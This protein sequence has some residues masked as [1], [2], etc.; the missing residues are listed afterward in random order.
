M[1]RIWSKK[2]DRSG[3]KDW[4]KPWQGEKKSRNV[5]RSCRHGGNCAYCQENREFRST[6]QLESTEDQIMGDPEAEEDKWLGC[7]YH[8]DPKGASYSTSECDL[9]AFHV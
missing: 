9:W 8:G 7:D 2:T 5:D 1:K 4:R 6:R 3:A